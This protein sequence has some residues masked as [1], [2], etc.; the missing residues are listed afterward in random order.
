[1]HVIHEAIRTDVAAIKTTISKMKSDVKENLWR[2]KQTD[3][4]CLK[5]TQ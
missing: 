2:Q 3:S 5:T 1:M 4:K